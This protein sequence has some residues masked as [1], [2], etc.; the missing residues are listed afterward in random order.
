MNKDIESRLK[1][2]RL[3]PPSAEL[4]SKVLANASAAWRK[5]HDGRVLHMQFRHVLALAASLVLFICAIA[6]LN[7]TEERRMSLSLNSSSGQSKMQSEN[8]K[9]L[10]EMGFDRKYSTAIACLPEI[11]RISPFVNRF[12]EFNM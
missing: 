2:L 12:E 4:R 10:E 9:F 8:I 3:T 5:E 6:L 11:K 1:E 7:R